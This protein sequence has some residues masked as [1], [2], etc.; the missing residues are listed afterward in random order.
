[1]K[2]VFTWIKQ[3]AITVY[4]A[5]IVDR[6]IRLAAIVECDGVGPDILFSFAYLLAIVLPVHTMPVK[7]V[8]DAVFETGPDGGTWIRGRRVDDNR[9]GSRTAT[10]VDPVFVPALAFFVSAFDVVTK[11]A[12]VPDVDRSV[13]ILNVVLGN[14]CRERFAG[15]GIRVNV[16]S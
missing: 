7:I 3:N 11:R 9:S 13:E 1:M 12:C 6:L 10:V 8:I 15:A 4:V 2:L 16:L 14:E 5:L